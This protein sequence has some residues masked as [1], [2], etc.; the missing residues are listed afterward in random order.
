MRLLLPQA[1]FGWT[2]ML[3]SQSPW[4]A[5]PPECH[6]QQLLRSQLLQQA[7]GNAACTHSRWVSGMMAVLQA[8]LETGPVCTHARQMLRVLVGLLKLIRQCWGQH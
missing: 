4:T 5:Q 7:L 8:T 3:L 2:L 6:S 1:S